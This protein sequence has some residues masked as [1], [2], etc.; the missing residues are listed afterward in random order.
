M[1]TFFLISVSSSNSSECTPPSPSPPHTQNTLHQPQPQLSLFLVVIFLVPIELTHTVPPCGCLVICL[2]HELHEG[3][4]GP[5]GERVSRRWVIVLVGRG[6]GEDFL[7]ARLGFGPVPIDVICVPSPERREELW[8]HAALQ[9]GAAAIGDEINII[10]THASKRGQ[11]GLAPARL[12][13]EN[14]KSI[15]GHG[16]GHARH[17]NAVNRPQVFF[18]CGR[19]ERDKPVR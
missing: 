19:H 2:A 5:V 4:R 1:M 13:V 17:F 18:N 9:L 12:V 11:K 6:H 16:Y 3:R 14:I 10:L 15:H 8:V 7:K